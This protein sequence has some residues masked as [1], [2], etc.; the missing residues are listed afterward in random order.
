MN[1]HLNRRSALLATAAAVLAS[2]PWAHAQQRP[3][4]AIALD[5]D[6]I[7]RTTTWP[8]RRPRTAPSVSATTHA[9]ASNQRIRRIGP[10]TCSAGRANE[11]VKSYCGDRLNAE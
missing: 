1:L 6:D 5:A 2:L 7:A 4:P 8:S 10:S 9:A 3:G 11:T